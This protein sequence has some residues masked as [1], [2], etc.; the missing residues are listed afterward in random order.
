MNREVILRTLIVLAVAVGIGLV[1]WRFLDDR[2]KKQ[3]NDAER[4]QRLTSLVA[5]HN[6]VTNWQQEKVNSLHNPF[7]IKQLQIKYFLLKAYLA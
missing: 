6:A 4:Q 3:A 1:G 7:N 2:T 5:Q